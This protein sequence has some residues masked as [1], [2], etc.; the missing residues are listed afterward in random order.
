MAQAA[1]G[2][3]SPPPS[4][5]VSNPLS[6]TAVE[7]AVARVAAGFGV[8]FLLQSLPAMLSQQSAL[9]P[10]Y[11]FTTVITMVAALAFAV[12]TSIVRRWVR[13]ANVIFCL[14]YLV[15]LVSWPFAAADPHHPPNDSPWI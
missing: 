2:P 10:L 4:R 5:R 12:V 15:F 8:A 14:V 6:R 9:N 1:S 11:Y 7:T 13:A 3:F